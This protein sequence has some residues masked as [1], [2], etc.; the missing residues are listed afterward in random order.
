MEPRLLG[1]V[2]ANKGLKAQE[3][4]PFSVELAKI[5]ERERAVIRGRDGIR[6]KRQGTIL[7]LII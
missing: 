6:E 1:T 5:A 3:K 4:A 7:L 2:P